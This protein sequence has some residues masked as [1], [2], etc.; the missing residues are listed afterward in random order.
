VRISETR[1]EGPRLIEP[2]VHGDERGFSLESFR[3]DLLAD[4]GIELNFVQDNH[5][6]SRQ[7]VVR[8]IHF[9][10]GGGS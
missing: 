8:G 9:G 1:L 3:A 10:R 6:H 7:R 4:A 5:S 2:V